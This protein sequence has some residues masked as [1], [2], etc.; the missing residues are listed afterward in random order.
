MANWEGVSEFVA[1][2]ETSSFT[3]AAQKSGISVA[4]VSRRVAAL[5]DRLGVKLLNRT[6]RKVF[7]HRSRATLL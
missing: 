6:T 5:E 1:V 4:K 7:S 3:A 2:A